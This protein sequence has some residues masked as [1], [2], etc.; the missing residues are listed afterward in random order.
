MADDSKNILALL[1]GLAKRVYYGETEITDEFLKQE[2]F[3]NISED[4]F[5]GLVG[6]CSSLLKS[7][8]SADMDL[9]QS[10]AFFTSQ[11][12]KPE[13][14]ITENQANAFRKFW[15]IHRNKIHEAVIA[16]STWN[17]TLKN[18]SWRIDIQSQA[19]HIDQINAPTAIMELKLGPNDSKNS[20][21]VRFEMDEERLNNVLQTMQEI[22]NE[23]NK[24]CEQ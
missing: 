16:R 8:V 20:E 21:V 2:I 6:K 11:M 3:P 19:R 14:G 12:K 10:E 17:N 18:V 22:E 15:K 5:S 1:N 23:V 24:H 4:E 13:G 7:M 9:N